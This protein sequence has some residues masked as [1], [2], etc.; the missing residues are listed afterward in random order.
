MINSKNTKD[1]TG[2]FP[3]VWGIKKINKKLF[4][5]LKL[6]KC[7]FSS[8]FSLTQGHTHI[9]DSRLVISAL[10]LRI[11]TLLLLLLVTVIDLFC[12]PL[13]PELSKMTSN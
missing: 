6:K 2:L 4:I 11:I 3:S 7:F 1:G 12:L 10:I 9:H 13:L 5:M 8:D